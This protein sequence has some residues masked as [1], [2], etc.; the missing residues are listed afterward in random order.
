MCARAPVRADIHESL[1]AQAKTEVAAA[2]D[3]KVEKAKA[4]AE[5]KVEKVETEVTAAKTE[6]ATDNAK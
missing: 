2:E 6:F 1:V 5:D 3:N 4:A